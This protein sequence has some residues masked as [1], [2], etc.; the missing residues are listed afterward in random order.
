MGSNNNT[1][2]FFGKQS[3]DMKVDEFIRKT[4][5]SPTK[6]NDSMSPSS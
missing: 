5:S 6:I 4:Y 1:Y 3:L 2:Q